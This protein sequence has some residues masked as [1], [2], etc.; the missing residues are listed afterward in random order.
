MGCLVFLLSDKSDG[1]NSYVGI[2][3]C[4]SLHFSPTIFLG[5]KTSDKTIKWL[6]FVR[7]LKGSEGFD[8]VCYLLVVPEALKSSFCHS[9]ALLVP[10]PNLTWKHTMCV[11]VL[12]SIS[13]DWIAEN[14]RVEYAASHSTG[15]FHRGAGNRNGCTA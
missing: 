7:V 13:N 14:M 8:H 15:S 12:A 2:W 10:V 11:K 1:R 5:I 3:A 9:M 6:G 4:A